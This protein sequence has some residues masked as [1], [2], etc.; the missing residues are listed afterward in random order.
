MK[1]APLARSKMHERFRKVSAPAPTVATAAAG[2]WFEPQLIEILRRPVE[3]GTSHEAH[4]IKEHE[5]GELFAKLTVLEA[6]TLH[7]RLSNPSATDDLATTFGRLILER[8]MRLLA[9][10][11]DARRRAAI[12]QA[13]RAA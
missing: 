10:L 4:R 9:F 12:T 2:S 7:K 8:R 3:S 6:W 5:I 11:G 13:K 1:N